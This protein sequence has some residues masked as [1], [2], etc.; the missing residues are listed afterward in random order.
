MRTNAT[1]AEGKLWAIVRDR[2]FVGHKFR[3]QVPIDRYIVDVLCPAAKLIV[4]LDGGQHAENTSDLERDAWLA[5][6]GYRVLR[7]WNNELTTNRNGVVE[8]IWHALEVQ[9]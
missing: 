3:R 8:A 6:Q 1:G 4:E 2:R 9:S 7:V 5:S